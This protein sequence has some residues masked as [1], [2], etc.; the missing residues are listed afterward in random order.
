MLVW[1]ISRESVDFHVFTIQDFQVQLTSERNICIAKANP[2]TY[3]D[4]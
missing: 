4:Q 1:L 3:L 2:N